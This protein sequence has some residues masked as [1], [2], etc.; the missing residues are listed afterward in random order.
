MSNVNHY[1]RIFILFVFS[2][3]FT[4]VVGCN[5][6]NLSTTLNVAANLLNSDCYAQGALTE[7]QYDD[8]PFWEK[9]LYSKNSCGL[10]VKQ[11]ASDI[12]EHWF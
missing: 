12:V 7:A 8:L 1:H 3:L 5:T 9:L 4:F 11:D 10:Y 6:D 2:M